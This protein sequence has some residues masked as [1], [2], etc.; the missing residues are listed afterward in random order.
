MPKTDPTAGNPII[1]LWGVPP[2]GHGLATHPMVR[3]L[4][5][6][7]EGSDEAHVLPQNPTAVPLPETADQEII[8]AYRIGHRIME[9]ARDQVALGASMG[10]L[11]MFVQNLGYGKVTKTA[12]TPLINKAPDDQ[13]ASG[14]NPESCVFSDKAIS[15]TLTAEPALISIQEMA[16]L[17]RDRIKAELQGQ[18]LTAF[19][20]FDD[21]CEDLHAPWDWC[22]SGG[23]NW[24]VQVADA[25]ASTETIIRATHAVDGGG[26]LTLSGF[27][28]AEQGRNASFAPDAN[29]DWRSGTNLSTGT[30]AG[31]LRLRSE[32][33]NSQ[34]AHA[35]VDVFLADA[36]F[37]GMVCSN[38]EMIAADNTD[39]PNF[40]T[41]SGGAETDFYSAYLGHGAH[42]PV[43]YPINNSD[44]SVNTGFDRFAWPGYGFDPG[45]G[46]SFKAYLCALK[47]K[48]Y[49]IT[50]GTAGALP[51]HPWVR[52]IDNF[53][54]GRTP[55]MTV[56]DLA[57][58]I[59]TLRTYP[60]VENII[61]WFNDNT[62]SG[63]EPNWDAMYS[64][65]LE[66]Y[67]L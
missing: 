59:R 1:T 30:T 49:A 33:A 46:Y 3:W 27:I 4:C 17:I 62:S 35:I 12:G 25:R 32:A 36:F 13:L 20:Y 21:D 34:H 39:Y 61:L 5:R 55:S 18:G 28:T 47:R 64:A 63:H 15:G 67:P 51:V 10:S 56:A 6:T 44:G 31:L 65:I 16:V 23:G 66:V 48:M 40:L 45:R 43:F 24:A 7:F 26:D 58:A 42:A 54:D 50:R 60:T 41:N 11:S 29:V 22:S 52:G 14:S 9:H 53:L 38:Y 2:E 57:A 37:T 8:D 19:G